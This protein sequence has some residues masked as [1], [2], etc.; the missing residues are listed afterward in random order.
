MSTNLR[1]VLVFAAVFLLAVG[2]VQADSKPIIIVSSFAVSEGTA[3]VG[4]DFTLAVKLS[5]VQSGWCAK[6]VVTTVSAGFPF[7]MNGLSTFYSGDLC[8]PD[9]ATIYMPMRIDP[10]ANGG[11]YQIAFTSTYET[12]TGAQYS[13][14][15]VINLFVNGSPQIRATII[16][17]LP[18]DIYPGDSGVITVS[19]ENTGEFQAS[20]L[21]AV[22]S[23]PS[24]IEV[25]SSK[26]Q[27]S[28]SVLAPKSGRTADFGIEVPAN[29]QAKIYPLTLAVSYLDENSL[30]Q[31]R[32]F[33]LNLEVRKKADF[34]AENSGSDSLFANQNGRQVRFM[35]KNTG[36]DSAKNVKVRLIPMFPFSTDGSARYADQIGQGKPAPVQLSVDIDKD[37]K[38]GKYVMDVLVDFEDA[39]GK[40][41]QDTAQL[42]LEVK[43]AG[44]IRSVFLGYWALWLAIAVVALIVIR[45]RMKKRR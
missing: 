39:N 35:L 2:V 24:P 22:L 44:F 19:I 17:S 38:P 20:A 10:S 28:I 32:A 12:S 37:A 11:F 3:S 16:N 25:K 36:T 40:K 26:S 45:K 42:A 23:A 1:F 27:S 4:Q 31:D 9:S 14:S 41:F 43:Q 5:S 33:T 29:A 7:I 18:V 15:N 13:S 21:S 30:L 34:S 8:A 6:T